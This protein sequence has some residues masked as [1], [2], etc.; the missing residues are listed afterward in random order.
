MLFNLQRSHKTRQCQWSQNNVEKFPDLFL[1]YEKSLTHLIGHFFTM[2]FAITSIKYQYLIFNLQRSQKTR[3]W[4]Q[5]N[6]KNV[7]DLFS[8][9]EQSLTHKTYKKL[10]FKT[11]FYTK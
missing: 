8:V 1:G 2:K 9:Y 3:Q 5:N 7:P 11:F 10:T 4:S 6:V